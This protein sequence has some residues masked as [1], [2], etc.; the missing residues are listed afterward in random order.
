M[1]IWFLFQSRHLSFSHLLSLT[2]LCDGL[3]QTHFTDGEPKALRGHLPSLVSHSGHVTEP[4]FEP[5]SV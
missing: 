3:S 1:T 5:K 2:A 4:S